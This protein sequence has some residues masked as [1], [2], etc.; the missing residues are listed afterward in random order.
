MA[1]YTDDEDTWENWYRMFILTYYK[2]YLTR[3]HTIEKL[4]QDAK[5]AWAQTRKQP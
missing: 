3:Y 4:T 2:D 1:G 5:F